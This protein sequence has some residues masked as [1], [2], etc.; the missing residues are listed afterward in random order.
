[1]IAKWGV[2][3][4]LFIAMI[5]TGIGL[6]A[7]VTGMSVDGSF[8]ALLPGIALFG[9]AGGVTFLTMFVGAGTGI[10]AK[11]QGVASALAS[12]S[13]QIGGAIGLAGLVAVA[14][15]TLHTETKI[16]GQLPDIVNGLHLAGWIGGAAAVLGAF[17]ALG[18][19]KTST[20]TIPESVNAPLET[21]DEMSIHS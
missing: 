1:M 7:L 18:I 6:G 5:G 8:W 19:K 15:S 3:A 20:T 4:T 13:Q 10:T 14:N 11:Q 16:A 12:T 21:E 17:F 2:R 9:L